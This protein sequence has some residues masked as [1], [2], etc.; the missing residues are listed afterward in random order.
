MT[1]LLVFIM[2]GGESNNT[3][4]QSQNTGCC[5]LD[6]KIVYVFLYIFGFLLG[7]SIFLYFFQF[8]V[9]YE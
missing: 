8:E 2:D 4:V 1:I 6:K 7:L 3:D 9:R 5:G